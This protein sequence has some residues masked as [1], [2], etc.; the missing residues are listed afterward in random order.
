MIV[1]VLL[2][3]GYLGA[4]KTTLLNHLLAN[5]GGRRIAAVVN[6]FGAIDI[7]AGLL[8]T[9]SDGVVS[10]KNGC[11][12]CSLQG[13]LLR[14]LA[15]VIKRPSPPD[16]IVIETSGVSDPAEIIRNLM[17]PVIFKVAPLETVV[18]LVDARRVLDEPE[19]AQ[20]ALWRSQLRAADFVLLTKTDLLDDEERGRVAEFLG[21]HRPANVVFDVVQG[22]VAPDLLFSRTAAGPRTAPTPALSASEPFASITWTSQAP[23]SLARFQQVVSA[24]AARTLRM[25]GV[26]VFTEHP[27]QPM[28]FQCVGTRATLSASQLAP[29]DGLT[30]QLVLIGREGQID[31]DEIEQVLKGIVAD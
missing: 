13:D 28:L 23:L 1:P 25:K 8:G 30:A 24:L 12:C 2:V 27:A 4:G 3:T 21:R 5:P 20:D 11:I 9:V 17:D 15:S 10:L 29:P 22:A 7:D 19:L 18:T 16:A 14:T 31:R 26:F 6:D